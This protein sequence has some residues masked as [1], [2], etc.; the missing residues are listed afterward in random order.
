MNSDLNDAQV[1][2]LESLVATSSLFGNN[3]TSAVISFEAT[4]VALV[5]TKDMPVPSGGALGAAFEFGFIQGIQQSDLQCQYWGRSATDGRSIINVTLSH[6]FEVDTTDA[7]KPWTKIP[8]RRSTIT[9]AQTAKPGVHAF[10]INAKHSDHPQFVL[11]RF[12]FVRGPKDILPR[13][14]LLRSVSCQLDFVT[15]FALFD[16]AALKFDSISATHWRVKWNHVVTYQERRDPAGASTFTPTVIGPE[17]D[18][19]PSGGSP[20]AVDSDARDV[21]AK[22]QAGGPLLTPEV[23][24]GR[25]GSSSGRTV[26]DEEKNDDFDPSFIT[27]AL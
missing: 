18:T 25:L 1:R 17:R 22:A 14:L 4:A 11:N 6:R 8:G 10:R 23:L 13:R 27:S 15:I 24:N 19:L 7:V 26:T 5:P 20:S 16:K 21:I 12:H 3:I 2:T 9:P